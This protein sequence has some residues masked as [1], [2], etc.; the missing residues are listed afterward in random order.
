MVGP[1]DHVSEHGKGDFDLI[2][3]IGRGL[4][5]FARLF[6]LEKITGNWL[7]WPM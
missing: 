1:L 7:W 2:Y 6:V 5:L 4:S 3:G